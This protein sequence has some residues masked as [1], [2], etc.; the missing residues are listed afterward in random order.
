MTNLSYLWVIFQPRLVLHRPQ[1]WWV[2]T[3]IGVNATHTVWSWIGLCE[4]LSLGDEAFVMENTLGTVS[5]DF[6][7]SSPCQSLE[8]IFFNF[9]SENLVGFLEVKPTNMCLSPILQL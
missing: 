5:N 6:Y 7:S 4:S 2:Q 8:G 9:C 1:S 3:G